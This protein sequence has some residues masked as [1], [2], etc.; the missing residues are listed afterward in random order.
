MPKHVE[1]REVVRFVSLSGLL[2]AAACKPDSEPAHPYKQVPQHPPAVPTVLD[3]GKA[4]TEAPTPP[5]ESPP[6]EEPAA[7]DVRAGAEATVDAGAAGAA[8][9]GPDGSGAAALPPEAAGDVSA[10]FYALAGMRL[11]GRSQEGTSRWLFKQNGFFERELHAP[12][13]TVTVW[14]GTWKLEAGQLG[15]AYKQTV[16]TDAEGAAAEATEGTSTLPVALAGK[17]KLAIGGVEVSVDLDD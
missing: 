5:P 2:L 6:S 14:N 9:G 17:L 13:R 7:A 8:V 11:V 12:D 1:L 4:P 3:A 10:R 15:L 16:R